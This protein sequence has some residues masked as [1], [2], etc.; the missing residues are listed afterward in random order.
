M[1]NFFS[2]GNNIIIQLGAGF[3]GRSLL[4]FSRAARQAALGKSGVEPPHSKVHAT[5]LLPTKS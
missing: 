1:L 2:I 3:L 5:R 4:T